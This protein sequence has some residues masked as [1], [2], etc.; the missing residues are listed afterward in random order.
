MSIYFHKLN[1]CAPTPLASYLK[2]FGILR[3]V[4]EQ[5]DPTARGAWRDETFVIATKL[6]ADELKNFFL[7]QY[8]PTPIISPWNRGSGF[9]STRDKSAKFLEKF[10]KSPLHRLKQYR[11]GVK[12]ARAIS[13]LSALQTNID[14]KKEFDR[15]KPIYISGC[16]LHWRG[17]HF[18]WLEAAII[19]QSNGAMSWPSLLGTGGNDGRLDFTD[20]FRQRIAELFD[21][22]NENAPIPEKTSELLKHALYGVPVLGTGAYAIGQYSPGM[23]GGANSSNGLDGKGNVNPW[24]FILFLEGT[25]LFSA[26][27]SRR[28]KSGQNAAGS[29]PFAL[30]AQS[31]GHLSS[32]ADDKATRGEQWMP[33]WPQFATLPEIQTLL[34]E[35]RAQL[36]RTATR[37]P[38]EMARAV[39]R[40]GVARGISA[41]ERFAYL[42]RNGQ[43]N[44][45]VP[46]GRWQ[47]S[48]QPRQ[49]LLG[50]LD[51]WL[52][53][54]HRLARGDRAANAL[55]TAVKRLDES[56]LAAT[57]NAVLPRRW[58]NI[59]L[60]IADI[61]LLAA[62]GVLDSKDPNDNK[63]KGYILTSLRPAW[64]TATDDGTTEFRL[65]LALATQYKI[66]R[67]WLPLNQFGKLDESG[68]TSVV[69]HG[70]DLVADTIAFIDRRLVESSKNAVRSIDQTSIHPDLCA[71]LRD[72]AAFLQG[73]LDH[74]RI[75]NLA[76]ALMALDVNALRKQAKTQLAHPD[77]PVLVD[78]A[79]ALFRLCLAP[80][81]WQSTVPVR[82]DVFRRL[83]SGD[84][85]TAAHLATRHLRA[86]GILPP[87]Q[88]TVGDARLYAASLAFPLSR[89]S[90]DLLVRAVTIGSTNN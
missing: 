60:A 14:N 79:F 13:T 15:L 11:D 25:I 38:V 35:S 72:I 50:D 52:V 64:I 90:R 19:L 65:A 47:V 9:L 17:P 16:R 2:A 23:A 3:L 5:V 32:S 89:S 61:D 83:A 8:A 87:V 59:L 54:L 49:E 84:I 58:Q 10:E 33:L 37:E 43:A 81:H 75:L 74:N 51:E 21:V 22:E 77:G 1:G 71:D 69:C 46:L 57:T 42:E 48:T 78:D 70:R 67:H 56:I 12:A 36:G 40:L 24:D 39:A 82:A 44:F 86:H 73:S 31:A 63:K 85:T 53:R 6:A 68:A 28:M 66:R 30:P 45:A 27:A 76:R 41:F 20:N 4:T 55:V 26:S 34:G 62:K 7:A 88:I 80:Q 18:K 29:A